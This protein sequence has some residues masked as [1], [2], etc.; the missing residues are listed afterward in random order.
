SSRFTRTPPPQIYSLSLHDA[1]PILATAGQAVQPRQALDHRA[2]V[3]ASPPVVAV[4]HHGHVAALPGARGFG[5]EAAELGGCLD[6]E[7]AG[8]CTT[9]VQAQ[10]VQTTNGGTGR[11]RPSPRHRNVPMKRS[12]KILPAR[13]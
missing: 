11:L 12:P 5:G 10:L 7:H 3:E 13:I 8:Q 6:G 1:L 9:F 4:R 2:V